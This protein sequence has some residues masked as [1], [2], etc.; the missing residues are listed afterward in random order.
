MYRVQDSKDFRKG[1]NLG[2]EKRQEGLLCNKTSKTFRKTRRSSRKTCF[3]IFLHS[4]LHFLPSFPRLSP[5][6]PFSFL[7][8]LSFF[9]SFFPFMRTVESCSCHNLHSS[10]SMYVSLALKVIESVAQLRKITVAL[11][12]LLQMP[13]EFDPGK[14][15]SRLGIPSHLGTRGANPILASKVR[16]K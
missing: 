1:R 9:A 8:H 6:L 12:K 14:Q 10:F 4:F 11:R 2:A 5:F 16:M 13:L 3:L 7:L 15:Y